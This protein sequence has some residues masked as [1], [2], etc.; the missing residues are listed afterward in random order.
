MFL[1]KRSLT[2]ADVCPH[3]SIVIV[4]VLRIY[5]FKG[6]SIPQISELSNPLQCAYIKDYRNYSKLYPSSQK[7]MQSRINK[8]I[9]LFVWLNLIIW[10]V[11]AF[12]FMK[13]KIGYLAIK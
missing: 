6:L 13:G 11:K 2:N 4:I 9:E 3:N 7:R 10:F 12:N 1:K 8:F 5:F